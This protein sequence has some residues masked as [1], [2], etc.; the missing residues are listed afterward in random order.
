MVSRE[1][2]RDTA[3]VD[4][5]FCMNFWGAQWTMVSYLKQARKGFRPPSAMWGIG[6]FQNLGEF[7]GIFEGFW[8]DFLGLLWQFYWNSLDFF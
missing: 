5:L 6:Y 8:G 1:H 3:A 7:W 2:E 4:N